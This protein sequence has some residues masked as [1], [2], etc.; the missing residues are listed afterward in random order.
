MEVW[1]YECG[2]TL[3]GKLHIDQVWFSHVYCKKIHAMLL[4]TFSV[5]SQCCVA[6][7]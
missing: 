7:R 1:H 2:V 3:H 4:E 5:L 6:I